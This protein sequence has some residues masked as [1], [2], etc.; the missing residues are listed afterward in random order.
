V[1]PGGVVDFM[2]HA[3]NGRPQRGHRKHG[4]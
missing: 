4:C 2:P 1:E 3:S